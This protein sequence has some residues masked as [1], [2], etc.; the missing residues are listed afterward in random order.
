MRH[1]L[2]IGLLGPMR[3]LAQGRPVAVTA[4]RR[5]VILA[6]LAIEV[7][8]P[9]S[10]EALAMY[11]WADEP[12]GDTRRAV[13]TVVTR[14]RQDLGMDV[15]RRMDGGYLLAIPAEAVDVHRF[16][17]LLRAARSTD[18]P[19]RLNLLDRALA[20]WRGEPLTNLSSDALVAEHA[21]MLSEEWY[22]ATQRRVD[23]L[24]AAGRHAELV[25][26]L[27]DLTVKQPLRE[28]L[29]CRLIVALYRCGRQ[30]EALQA[31]RDVRQLLA[32]QLGIAPG[33]ELTVAHH[34]VLNH[35]PTVAA[36]TVMWR[37]R[38][39]A[40]RHRVRRL[41]RLRLRN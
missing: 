3:V 6:A 26:H 35:S 33:L 11:M 24:L 8:Q 27:R 39:V 20:C 28:W 13:A 15:I 4:P 36:P 29:W 7:G 40:R 19:A 32:D 1:P 18:G 2:E 9:V 14:L 25:P 31:Y 12:R 30:A 37:V 10:S 22:A 23:L 41:I 21:P 17:S 5:Q 16:R 34:A 38:P